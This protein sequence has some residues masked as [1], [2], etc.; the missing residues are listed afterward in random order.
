MRA[1]AAIS[2]PVGAGGIGILRVSGEDALAVAD[3]IFICAGSTRPLAE[4]PLNMRFGT[5]DAGDFKD[6]GY[7]VFFPAARAYAGEDTME[8]YL[9]GGVRIMQGALD[10]AL[11]AGAR[12]AERGEF[13]KRAYLAGRLSLADAEG[14]ADMIGAESAAALRAAY[15][16]MDGTLSRE[17]DAICDLVGDIITGL[18]AVLDY[19]E[20]T[21][22]EVLP[23]LDG[24]IKDA[25]ARVDA[26]L[27][28]ADTG[29]MAKHGITAVLAGRP[30]A[31]KSSLMNALLGAD[32][33]IV[34]DTP[35]TTRDTIEGSFECD[36]VRINLVDTA[37]IRESGDA[38]ES[39]GVRRA[40]AAAEHADV[41]L[42]VVDT[43]AEDDEEVLLDAARV[44]TVRNKCDLTS[45]KCPRMYGCFAVSAKDGTGVEELRH[46]IAALY[47][48]G[49]TAD[50]EVITSERHKDALYRAKRALESAIESL[51]GT[52]DLTLVDLSEAYDALGE[53][54]G[55]T[56]TEDV[57]DA[58]FS[59]FCVGK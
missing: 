38:I 5:F 31:G 18:E 49:K 42:H 33:A 56:A 58:I 12:L 25:L 43:T 59:K 39:E 30:N 55:K 48:E 24:Q 45:Y 41:V 19:P 9:H 22:D 3:A 13:T 36:G 4:T 15:R 29:R 14:V 57:V 32:R 11:R 6:K 35:G 54:T 47:A 21:E 1:I 16:L 7:A 50:G 28:T 51:D 52:V 20:E 53:I 34:T 26:L 46:A 17:I 2:T 8:F 44:F 27:A 37:G 23:P 40:L 10:A